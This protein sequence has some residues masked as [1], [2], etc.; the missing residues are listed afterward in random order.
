MSETA[1]HDYLSAIEK[2]YQS[3][4]ATEHTYR[5]ALKALLEALDANVFARNEPKRIKCGAP[6]YMIERNNLTIGYIEAK[7]IDISLDKVEK[8]EQLKRY[9]RALDNLILTN[10]LEFRWYV[11]G[12]KRM[13]ACLA[14]PRTDRRLRLDKEGA[15]AVEEILRS[16]LEHSAE[17]IRKPHELAKRMARLAHMIR[18]IT[19][20]AFEQRIASRNLQDLYQAFQD[21]LLPELKPVEFADMFAQTMAYGL[22]AARY[23]HTQS[24]PFRRDDAAREIPAPILFCAASLARLQGRIL[25]KSHLSALLTS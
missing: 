24:R 8:D 2:D 12:E 15:V 9:L 11:Q 13:T 16:F 17:P 6:D 3:G 5:G 7:D 1:L 25:M 20:T 22:F 18:D 10:Y 4:Q 21:V 19:T 14:T 23:N